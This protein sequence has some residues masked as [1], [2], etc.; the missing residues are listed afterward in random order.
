[1]CGTLQN[2]M[3]AQL[4]DNLFDGITSSKHSCSLTGSVVIPY[5]SK[6]LKLV[7]M[8]RIVEIFVGEKFANLK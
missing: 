4:D 6:V 8:Y 1:M 7:Q 2:G 3:N 5:S